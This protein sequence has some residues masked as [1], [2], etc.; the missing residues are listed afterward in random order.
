MRTSEHGW[1]TIWT[2]AMPAKAKAVVSWLSFRS[3]LLSMRRVVTVHERW[4]YIE[5][6]SNAMDLVSLFSFDSIRKRGLYLRGEGLARGG[7]WDRV[8]QSS[9]VVSRCG[10]ELNLGRN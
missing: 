5:L 8:M 4:R 2:N 3:T 9:H 10:W 6:N 1:T 7:V